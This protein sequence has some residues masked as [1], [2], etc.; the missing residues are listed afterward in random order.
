MMSLDNLPSM[1]EAP[2]GEAILTRLATEHEETIL[3]K[4]FADRVEYETITTPVEVVVEERLR[5][6]E[7]TVSGEVPPGAF[8]PGTFDEQAELPPQR[9]RDVTVELL[10][11]YYQHDCSNCSGDGSVICSNCR[12]DGKHICSR[13]N[14]DATVATSE[15]CDNCGGDGVITGTETC[16]ECQGR[17]RVTVDGE[18]QRCRAC[19]GGRV[20]VENACPE[21]GGKGSFDRQGPCPNCGGDVRVTCSS[22]SGGGRTRCQTC[23]GG[24]ESIVYTADRHDFRVDRTVLD[25]TSPGV[26]TDHVW[27]DA[28][29]VAWR[30]DDIQGLDDP[31]ATLSR[32]VTYVGE[33]PTVTYEYD[34][35]EHE[36]YAVDGEIVAEDPPSVSFSW[37]QQVL[38]LAVLAVV[39][40]YLFTDVG[41]LPLVGALLGLWLVLR[42]WR[43]IRGA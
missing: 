12:G 30:K 10:E 2:D 3:P 24:G 42:I 5:G 16:S 1:A 20:D 17:G 31:D 32:T 25:V 29:G 39:P 27:P 43:R 22:C 33:I 4:N 40:A 26:L 11:T 36:V 38:M 41:I 6:D 18:E 9:M 7:E 23:Q 35:E 37:G 19:S 13:C 14:G 28:D 34:G 21:C 15:H 8:D